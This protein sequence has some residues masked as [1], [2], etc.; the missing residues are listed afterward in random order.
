MCMYK[1]LD[2]V[3]AITNGGSL[4]QPY[5]KTMPVWAAYLGWKH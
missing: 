3:Y 1:A 2:I 4:P 5:N